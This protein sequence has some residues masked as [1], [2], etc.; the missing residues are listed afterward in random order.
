MPIAEI[1]IEIYCAQC[2]AGLC[3][4]TEFATTRG[5]G[6]PSFRVEPCEKC[7]NEAREEAR[8]EG[9]RESEEC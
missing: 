8:E 9:R 4:Q 2:G 6:L 1:E 7:L 3:N 5:R